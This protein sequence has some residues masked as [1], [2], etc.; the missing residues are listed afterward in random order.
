MKKIIFISMLFMFTGLQCI[1]LNTTG[2]TSGHIKGSKAKAVIQDKVMPS[3]LNDLLLA[4]SDPANS[5]TYT[6]RAM[7]NAMTVEFPNIDNNQYY[8]TKD[9]NDFADKITNSG[10]YSLLGPYNLSPWTSAMLLCNLKPDNSV[11]DP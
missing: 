7:L 4:T 9:V 11:W 3:I 5:L 1:L 8:K 10:I 6:T 2:L